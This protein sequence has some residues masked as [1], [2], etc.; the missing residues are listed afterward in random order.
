MSAYNREYQQDYYK[1][2]RDRIISRAIMWNREHNIGPKDN[3]AY[4][5]DNRDRVLAVNKAWK[6]RNKDKIRIY[7]QVRR[8]RIRSSVGLLTVG[9]WEDIKKSFGNE[10]ARCHRLESEILLTIDHIIPVSKGGTNERDNLQPL[11]QSCNSKKFLKIIRFVPRSNL[12][13]HLE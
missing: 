10:C 12:A 9:I 4:Y 6:E 5:K 2:N 7:T 3:T 8:N 13:I 11:C 1:K